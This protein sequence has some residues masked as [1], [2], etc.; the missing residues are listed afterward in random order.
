MKNC[1]LS[2]LVLGGTTLIAPTALAGDVSVSTSIDYVTDYVFRGVSLADSAVQPGVEL[3]T[4]DFYIGAWASTGVGNTSVFAG[5]EIDLYA[6]YG[7]AL[8][9]SVSADLGVTYYHYPQGG[10]LFE[11]DGGAAGTYEVYAGLAFDAP[12]SPSVYGYYDFT[13]E[14]FTV[15]GSVGHSVPMGPKTSLDLGLAAGLVDGDGFGWEYGQASAAVGYS[16]TDDVSAYV[17]ANFA[18]NSDDL[19]NYEEFFTGDLIAQ[20]SLFFFGAGVAAGF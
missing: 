17:G 16:F 5:D 3:A 18:L 7:V 20:D 11:T 1:A 9:D 8:S 19:L 2:L 6:G 12:L 13:L 15:E 10:G 4:G 14:A